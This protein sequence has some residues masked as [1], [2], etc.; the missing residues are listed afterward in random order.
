[1]S[2]WAAAVCMVRKDLRVYFRDRTGML[3]GLLLPIA[4]VTVFGMVMKFAFGGGSGMPRVALWVADQDDSDGSRRFVTALRDV[5][6]L[7]V[8]P[9]QDQDP[10]TAEEVRARVLDGEAHHALIV[11]EGFGDALAAGTEPPL[12]LVRDP[13]RAM[14][15][16]IVGIGLMQATMAAAG[17]E[18]MPWLLGSVMRRQGMS[19]EGVRRV[20]A[21]MEAVQGVIGRFLGGEDPALEEPAS[22]PSDPSFDMA[23]MFEDM[24]P[25]TKEDVVPPDR[26]KTLGYQLAQSV[27]GMVVMMLMFGIMACSGMLLVERDQG[28]LRR[29]MVARAPRSALLLGTFLF[30]LVGGLL[31]LAVLF[32]YGELVFAVGAFRDPLTLLGLS[33]TWA[34]AATSFGMLIAVWARTQKQAEGLATLLI[35]VMAALGGCWFP[36]QMAELPWYADVVTKSTLTYWA[37]EGFQG[38]FWH[39]K[40]LTDPVL[41][42]AMGVQ[43]GFVAVATWLSWRLWRRRFV[44]A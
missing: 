10:A 4:L 16:R 28:T 19:D 39:Q 42:R 9:R 35:L 8:R 12:V 18:A 44:G 13:G 23:Q 7:S 38:M 15:A 6:M 14:E 27:S 31:V 3:L 17:G 37:M 40:A 26:P 41:L 21:G 43:W 32:T 5:S 2:V 22:P 11:G 30:C 24:V 1:M 33:V 34:A 36:I 25:V 29:L 20:V